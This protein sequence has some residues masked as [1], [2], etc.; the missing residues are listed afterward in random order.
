MMPIAYERSL[1][2]IL[3]Y[4]TIYFTLPTAKD[5]CAAF[6]HPFSVQVSVHD[7]SKQWRADGLSFEDP[8]ELSGNGSMESGYSRSPSD[9]TATDD[10]GASL[11]LT[12]VNELI[13]LRI[14]VKF[15]P[16][17]INPFLSSFSFPHK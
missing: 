8:S 5:I 6:E 16:F 4:E 1:K 3:G 12:R 2:T 14:L 15:P 10:S 7:R 17:L 9:S 13:L 11:D